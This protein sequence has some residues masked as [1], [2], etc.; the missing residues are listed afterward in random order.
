VGNESVKA[1]ATVPVDET[2]AD[3]S[4]NDCAAAIIGAND[5]SERDLNICKN[6]GSRR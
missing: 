5:N 1:K 2:V 3:G 6:D 4:V